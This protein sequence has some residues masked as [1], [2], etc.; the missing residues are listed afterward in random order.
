MVAVKRERYANYLDDPQHLIAVMAS[1][2][3]SKG[4]L[5]LED[6]K[7]D[8]HSY[9]C[10]C[11][12]DWIS[13]KTTWALPVT[14]IEHDALAK[15]LKACSGLPSLWVSHGSIPGQHRLLLRRN[16]MRPPRRRCVHR[17]SAPRPKQPAQ[18]TCR[19]QRPWSRIPEVYGAQC[20]GR[21][22]RGLREVAA[23]QLARANGRP[24]PRQAFLPVTV[25]SLKNVTEKSALGITY[26]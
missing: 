23:S 18:P 25:A 5:V 21:R 26:G 14:K 9:W 22:W 17:T 13:I 15:M 1:A 20:S 7:P 16:H 19:E 10:Q 12:T 3:R 4:A 24:V 6:W 8:D 2:N 11:A